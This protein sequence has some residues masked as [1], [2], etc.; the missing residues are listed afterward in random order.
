[1][2]KRMFFVSIGVLVL[3]LAY[4]PAVQVIS[5]GPRDTGIHTLGH[6][7]WVLDSTGQV[8]LLD[9]VGCWT[10][11]PDYDIPIPIGDVAAW[12]NHALITTSGIAWRHDGGSGWVECGPWPG[13]PTPLESGSWGQIKGRYHE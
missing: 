4:Q 9:P 12:D 6:N 11:Q 5:A 7:G 3:V 2:L 10:R 1:M 13:G 8:W